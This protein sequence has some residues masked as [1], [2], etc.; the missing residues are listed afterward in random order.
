MMAEYGTALETQDKTLDVA[1]A[2]AQSDSGNSCTV[3][4]K[5][6]PFNEGRTLK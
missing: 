4:I 5:T 2:C 1:N 6:F 3:D